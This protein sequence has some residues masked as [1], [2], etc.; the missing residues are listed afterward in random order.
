MTT[1]YKYHRTTTPTQVGNTPDSPFYICL[2]RTTTGSQWL[3]TLQHSE[4]V[5]CVLYK[6]LM[7]PW[8]A[9]PLASSVNQHVNGK[10]TLLPVVLSAAGETHGLSKELS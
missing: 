1:E 2:R 6:P 4:L 7:Q 5:P 9:N 3:Q 10:T 8:K